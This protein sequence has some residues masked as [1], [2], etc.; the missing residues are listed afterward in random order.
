MGGGSAAHSKTAPWARGP[1]IQSVADMAAGCGTVLQV[2]ERPRVQEEGEQHFS[3]VDC[4][5]V[6]MDSALH[7]QLGQDGC[8]LDYQHHPTLQSHGRV[9]L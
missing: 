5:F 6:D 9:M 4:W 3:H 1:S 2:S 8:L 7:A